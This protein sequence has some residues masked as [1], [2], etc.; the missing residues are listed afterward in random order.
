MITRF[1]V[2][3]F[4][5]ISGIDMPLSK[6]NCLVGMNGAGKST[7]LQSLDFAARQMT[8]DIEGWLSQR[9]WESKD[10]SCKLRKEQNIKMGLKITL[11]NSGKVISWVFSFN[12]KELRCT[13][14]DF[15]DADGSLVFFPTDKVT[16]Q[17][18]PS[19]ILVS[20]IKVPFSHSLKTPN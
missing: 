13:S 2:D 8:G 3:N 18:A 19:V 16:Q 9:G 15:R 17:M 20:L 7:L 6:F 4:K 11:P 5:S 12:K 14:E 1:A 10:L